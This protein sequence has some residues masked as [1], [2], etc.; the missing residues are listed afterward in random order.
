MESLIAFIRLLRPINLG[1]IGVTM[2][3]MRWGLQFT[4]LSKTNLFTHFEM[5]EIDF[6][7][8]TLVMMLLA[9]AGN[10]INDYFDVKVDKLNK[11][12]RVLVGRKVK[13]RVAMF[14]HHA[15]NVIAV[16][17]TAYLGYKYEHYWAVFIPIAMAAF[18]WFYSMT[19][20][21]QF[22]IG[23]IV[24]ASLVA[25]VPLWSGIF[26]LHSLTKTIDLIGGNPQRF[27]SETNLWL[28]GYTA[29]AFI[30]TL[31][32]EV[33]KDMEDVRGDKIEG[34]DTLPVRL[35]MKAGKRYTSILFLILLV[36]ILFATFI[37]QHFYYLTISLP[38]FYGMIAIGVLVPLFTSW[39]FLRTAKSKSGF[40]KASKWSKLCMAGGIL[41]AALL[42][43]WF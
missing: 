9:G 38:L 28:L 1:I 4:L 41:I 39:F 40:T 2:Y 36:G 31:I 25:V 14:G 42:P 35:G 21:R 37:M 26:E 23:N 18:L 19:F 15:I 43:F 17:I 16:A 11:P 13:R 34:F 12:E 20:K 24:V 27:S 5:S 29:F 8:S 3:A 32:R 10:L 33:Q 7:L 22:L 30:I 6:A